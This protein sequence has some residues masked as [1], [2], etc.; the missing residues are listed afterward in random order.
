MCR[1]PSAWYDVRCTPPAESSRYIASTLRDLDFAGRCFR[2]LGKAEAGRRPASWRRCDGQRPSVGRHD[3]LNDR[4]AEPGP[5]FCGVAGL[6]R[7]DAVA[8]AC[9]RFQPLVARSTRS[10]DRG[11]PRCVRRPRAWTN[12][13]PTRLA[14]ALRTAASTPCTMTG[15][16]LE[17]CSSESS[18][19]ASSA[20]G[21]KSARTSRVSSRQIDG[22]L[23]DRM[24]L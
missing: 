17:A 1:N 3:L 23:F 12:A 4:Q 7:L 5:L 21:L 6:E 20:E 14:K 16:F 19:P 18:I 13:L 15:A 11:W 22:P 24:I 8:G 2:S 9:E 10:R